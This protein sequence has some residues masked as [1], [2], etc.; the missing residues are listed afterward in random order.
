MKVRLISGVY[1]GRFLDAPKS[2]R[3]HPMS[4]RV[5]ASLFNQL[6]DVSGKTVLDAFA[7]TGAL[8]FEAL[9]RGAASATFVERDKL[10]QKVLTENIQ[11]LGVSDKAKLIKSGV[12][13]WT[14]TTTGQS[15]D[16]IFVDPPYHDLQL[17]TVAK[18][19]KYLQP[20]GLM[21]L[22]FPG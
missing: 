18:L 5:R 3:T 13:G 9:S 7:G 8:G 14:D 6:G 2:T 10:A 12:S 17:S 15:F 20:N 16:L 4:E 22:S 19:V 1:G 11:S 21:I